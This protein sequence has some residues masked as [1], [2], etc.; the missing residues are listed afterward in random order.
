MTAV[1]SRVVAVAAALSVLCLLVGV[2]A[3]AAQGRCTMAQVAGKYVFES[4][5]SS[6]FMLGPAAA[7]PRHWAL[8]S[9]PLTFVGSITVQPDGAMSG[10][11]WVILGTMTSGL[12]AMPFDG[13]LTGLDTD[14]CTAVLEWAGSF[15]PGTPPGFHRERVVFLDNGREFRSTLIQ[16]PSKTM[17]WIGRGHRVALAPAG[18]GTHVLK[19][20]ALLQCEA[21]SSTANPSVS[22]SAS[23]LFL[24]TVERNGS[25]TGMSYAKNARYTEEPVE[26]AFDVQAGWAIEA[27]LRSPA[28][29][30]VVHFGRGVIFDQGKGGF[31]I[32]PLETQ[33]EFLSGRCVRLGHASATSRVRGEGLSES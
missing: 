5:G 17:A 3:A 8:T 26:G 13:Q 31:L 4:H 33:G 22:G 24:L 2:G 14:T 10:E 27:W 9:A 21:L 1:Q 28:L 11:G 30:D 16:S 19:G 23:T 18:L 25:F 32:L 29:P 7:P 15:V 12:T 20:D 6:T